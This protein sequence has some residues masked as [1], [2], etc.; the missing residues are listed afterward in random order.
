MNDIGS[1]LRE[2]R[3]VKQLSLDD[4][5]DITKI[6]KRYLQA[7][8]EG[9][10]DMMPGAFYVRA[11]VKQ[12]AEAV[13][14][15]YEELLVTYKMDL[16]ETITEEVTNS[17]QNT[18]SR[19]KISRSSS[20]L[21]EAMPKIVVALFIIVLF[22]T[23]W[24]F[25]QKKLGND[26]AVEK[27]QAPEVEYVEKDPTEAG[28]VE[29]DEQNEEEATEEPVAPVP[30]LPQG[31]IQADGVTT[32]YTLSETDTMNLRV[33]AYG[34]TW[35]GIRNA[36][37]AEQ[38]DARAYDNGEVVEFDATANGF[39]RIRL[40]DSTKAKVFVNGE[41]LQYAQTIVTQNIIIQFAE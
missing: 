21:V 17:I 30:T 5:Q 24:F 12:Y 16:P 32:I 31:E 29:D 8:E 4:L 34:L 39:A 33:E 35:I 20:K 6:Q 3:L 18:P 9:N 11:F 1:R 27:E 40:G 38:V 26:T 10:F 19:R 28:A 25:L 14:L 2:A 41:E 13:G 36:S 22:I 7:I 37:A 15:N 23:F